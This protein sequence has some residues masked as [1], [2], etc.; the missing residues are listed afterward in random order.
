[1][2]DDVGR[3]LRLNFA[4][5]AVPQLHDYRIDTPF[6]LTPVSGSQSMGAHANATE[7]DGDEGDNYLPGNDGDAPGADDVIKGFGGEDYCNGRGGDD[8]LYGGDDNDTLIGENGHDELYGGDG[9][10]Q[11]N[12]GGGNQETFIMDPFHHAKPTEFVDGGAG[13]DTLTVDYAGWGLESNPDKPISVSIDITLGQGDVEVKASANDKPRPGEA[14]NSIEVLNFDGPDGNDVAV[15]GAFGDHI[16]GN[17]GMDVLKG[18]GGDD[19]ISD[20]TGRIDADGGDGNDEFRLAL[21]DPKIANKQVAVDAN[22][23]TVTIAGNSDGTFVNFEGMSVSIFNGVSDTVVG[24]ANG[25]NAISTGDGSDTI[26]GGSQDDIIQANGGNNTVHAGGGNDSVTAKGGDDALY[27][28]GGND[29]LSGDVDAPSGTGGNDSLYGGGGDDTIF[30]GVL[31][32][33]TDTISGGSGNDTIYSGNQ[34]I[35]HIT[36]DAGDDSI[37]LECSNSQTLK[38]ST[39]D[40]GSGTDAF[41]PF[42]WTTGTIDISNASYTGMEILGVETS[43]TP[44][45]DFYAIVMTSAQFSAFAAVHERYEGVVLKDNGAIVLKADTGLKSLQLAN[46]GQSVDASQEGGFFVPQILGGTG[47]DSVIGPT[48]H[49]SIITFSV[50]LGGG[51]DSYTGGATNATVLGGDG[52]DTLTAG[53]AGDKF[54]GGANADGLVAGAGADRFI[55]TAVTDSTGPAFDTVTGFDANAQDKFDLPFAVA[56][57]DSTV[58]TGTLSDATF[59][60]DLK[61]AIGKHQLD[62]GHAVLFTPDAGGHAGQTFLIVDANGVKGYQ[63]GADYVI[64]LDAGHNLAM[65]DTTD[66]I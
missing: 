60:G 40:G 6:A 18:M 49:L 56:A 17:G 20:S 4:H 47:A 19:V 32:G 61:T 8:K 62:I 1:M 3:F 42:L 53:S 38:H 30:G 41:D 55:Y 36:G 21:T 51:N 12:G 27:G 46:G 2:R 58:G 15:G 7:I 33:G 35:S 14:F 9:D 31:P 66:F 34:A 50:T 43:S 28:E 65:L 44:F 25:K 11:L 10:D 5:W 48:A 57:I 13:T 24:F 54:T 39:V 64:R 23:G 59:N 29:T 37:S 22:A 63:A 16:S 52:N 26:T 45:S